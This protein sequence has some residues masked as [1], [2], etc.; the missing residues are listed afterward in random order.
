V[1]LSRQ[2][3]GAVHSYSDPPPDGPDPGHGEQV[4]VKDAVGRFGEQRAVDHLVAAGLTVLDRNWRCRG[5]ELDVVARDGA[6]LVIVE[7]KTRSSLVFGT[8]AEAVDRRKA[9]RIRQL[10][11][12]WMAQHRETEAPF[13]TSVRFDVIS[14]LRRAGAEVTVDHLVGAF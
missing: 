14:V 2:C 11:V 5:G 7:V 13:W 4:R 10:A 1:G 3:D 8:P 9:A 6:Q 12:Q